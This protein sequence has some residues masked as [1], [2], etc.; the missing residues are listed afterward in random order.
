[1]QIMYKNKTKDRFVQKWECQLNEG[2]RNATMDS[3]NVEWGCVSLKAEQWNEPR[4][5]QRMRNTD[6]NSMGIIGT[7]C[8][9]SLL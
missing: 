9:F 4:Q 1:M 2:T 3:W 8:V 5:T 7:V 6:E